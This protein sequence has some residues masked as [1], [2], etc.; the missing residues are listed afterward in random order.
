MLINSTEYISIVENIKREITDDFPD[1]S[2]CF[3]GVEIKG[4]VSYFLWEKGHDG[5]C[6]IYTHQNGHDVYS[7]RPLLEKGLDG[8]ET[9]C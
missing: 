2:E 5:D 6:E 9:G 8:K 1:A 4:G 3:P 7:V